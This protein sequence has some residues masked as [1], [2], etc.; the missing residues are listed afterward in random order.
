MKNGRENEP[1]EGD[2]IKNLLRK[3]DSDAEEIL[4]QLSPAIEFFSSRDPIQQ[5]GKRTCSNFI[6]GKE[7]RG[8]RAREGLASSSPVERLIALGE[9][10]YLVRCNVVHGSKAQMGDDEQVIEVSVGPLA[11]LLQRAIEVTE[12][13]LLGANASCAHLE[14]V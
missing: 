8:R 12:K 7:E 13:H 1:S 5:M 11:L 14:D 9:I 10:I 3:L 4:G 2:Q 6:K